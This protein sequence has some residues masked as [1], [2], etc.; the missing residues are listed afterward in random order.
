MNEAKVILECPLGA[1]CERTSEDG[2]HRCM[3]HI[4]VQGKDPQSEK[5]IDSSGCAMAFLPILLVENAQT[6]RGQTQ[7]I[8]SFRNE[9][10]KGMHDRI[11]IA[12]MSQRGKIEQPDSTAAKI[13]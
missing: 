5:V 12:T 11:N 4:H 9:L 8:E 7:A 10:I 13:D 1:D 6:N 3:W 2:I